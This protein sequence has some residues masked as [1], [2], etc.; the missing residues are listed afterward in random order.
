MKRPT[1]ILCSFFFSIALL[2]S[3]KS[4]ERCPAYGKEVKEQEKKEERV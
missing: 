1:L 4:T 3:C 2:A